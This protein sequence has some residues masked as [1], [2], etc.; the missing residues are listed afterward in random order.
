MYQQIAEYLAYLFL[1]G[2]ALHAAWSIAVFG[3]M[4][5]ERISLKEA[6]GCIWFRP[7]AQSVVGQYLEIDFSDKEAADP[8]YYTFVAVHLIIGAV[9]PV[10]AA[11]IWPFAFIVV[12]AVAARKIRDTQKL[13]K[14]LREKVGE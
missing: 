10:L 7:T 4:W 14:T 8:V 2:Y 6:A 9:L 5:V 12:A 11:L 13:L 1:L 3:Y